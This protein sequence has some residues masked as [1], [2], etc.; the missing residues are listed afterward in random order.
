MGDPKMRIKENA[1][2]AAIAV[3]GFFLEWKFHINPSRIIFAISCF[4]LAAG[5]VAFL[6][7]AARKGV[8]PG[9]V[10]RA[11]EPVHFWFTIVLCVGVFMLAMYFGVGAAMRALST[12]I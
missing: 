1:Y 3:G 8:L 12:S 10:T 7:F 2:V 11:A 4:L 9:R 5:M 6:H